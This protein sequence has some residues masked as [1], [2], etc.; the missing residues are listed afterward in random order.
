VQ[1][2]LARRSDLP[3]LVEIYNQAVAAQATADL[4]PVTVRGRESWFRSHDPDRY[5]IL[6]A[7]SGERVC[8]WVSLSDYRSG[9]RAVRHTA[10]VSYYVHEA[11]RRKGVA[12]RLVQE[13]LR[14]TADLGIRIVFAILLEDNA[15]SVALLERLGF[16]R[17]GRL[18][19]VAE[20]DGREVS[21]LYYG[22]DIGD[23][24]SQL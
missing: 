17:W 8:G 12:T 6:V 19:R 23:R 10:E 21:H 13:A 7:D 9:R 24:R 4:D 18:P 5:P 1:I 3:A 22:L 14:R 11:H 16:E 2:R 15:A 20:F